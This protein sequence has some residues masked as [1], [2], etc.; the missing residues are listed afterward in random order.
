MSKM[1]PRHRAE[2]D[3]KE[4]PVQIQSSTSTPSLDASRYEAVRAR[5]AAAEGSFFYSVATT[6]VYCRP[7]CPARLA[8]RENVAFH[9]TP[10]EAERAGY[11]PCKRC[12]PREVPQLER[13]LQIVEATRKRL[14]SSDAPLGLAAL[15]AS[16]GLSPHY[17]HRLFKK[18]SGMTPREYAAACRLRRVGAELRS[19][20]TVTAAIY[21]AG[22]S[23]SS[24]F[25]EA[26]SGA[27]GMPPSDL[28]R[29]A[30]GVEM[31]AVVATCSLGHV[32]VAATSRGVCAITFGDTPE[33][34]LAELRVR[35]PRAVVRSADEALEALAARV[36]A[37]IDVAG[38]ASSIPLDLMGTAFQQK[39]WRELRAIPR[40]QTLTYS[41]I[42]KRIGAPR[43]V[44]A[45]GSACGKNPVAVVVPCHRVV[46]GDGALG[47]YR[48][49][50]DRKKRLLA[51]ERS[52]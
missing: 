22:Y 47:G 29:G 26:G 37:L 51:Q 44:R 35:F 4:H 38:V 8:L 30:A 36:I 17:F 9:S 11:R 31:R 50:L 52:R 19:G 39:V 43:A 6:G 1:P 27:L 40:G 46:R 5:D 42:A 48:W 15:A 25:Y 13:H 20:S 28:R 3:Q 33:S 23:S 10:D 21:E 16:A 24:R 45:V 12:R 2:R 18:H 49:G 32:L 14:E 7:T 41:E 34:L